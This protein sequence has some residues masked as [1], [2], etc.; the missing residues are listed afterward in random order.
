MDKKQIIAWLQD[1]LYELEGGALYTNPATRAHRDALDAVIAG[2]DQPVTVEIWSEVE[3]RAHPHP[4][5][6][7]DILHKDILP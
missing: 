5:V 2:M 4:L 1:L 7:V 6:D 3:Q